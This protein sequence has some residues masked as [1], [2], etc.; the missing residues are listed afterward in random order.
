MDVP[1][2]D[3]DRFF[4]INPLDVCRHLIPA[5]LELFEELTKPF[6]KFQIPDSRFGIF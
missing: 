1:D 5:I 6:G 3:L 4:V 2:L